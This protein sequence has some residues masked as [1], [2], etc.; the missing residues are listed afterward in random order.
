MQMNN[1]IEWVQNK[2]LRAVWTGFIN[3][4]VKYQLRTYYVDVTK[5]KEVLI[6]KRNESYI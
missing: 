5:N 2:F 3:G 4:N 1:D 6:V